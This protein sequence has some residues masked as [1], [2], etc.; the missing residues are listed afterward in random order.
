[1]LP[2]AAMRDFCW[3]ADARLR[4]PRI[5]P[6]EKE[7]IEELAGFCA[8]LGGLAELA[9]VAL[10][11]GWN[12]PDLE[13]ELLTSATQARLDGISKLALRWLREP[14]SDLSPLDLSTSAAL[15]EQAGHLRDRALVARV[16]SV[17]AGLEHDPEQALDAA[18]R[19]NLFGRQD[20]RNE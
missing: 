17:A 14:Q 6:F 7:Q 13:Q 3:D 2:G 20:F 1:P 10:L 4:W 19:P 12:I 5:P 15:L 18:S 16:Q 11:G 8:D 9:G